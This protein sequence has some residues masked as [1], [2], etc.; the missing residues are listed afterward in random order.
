MEESLL[1]TLG[2]A[3]V[4]G[5]I[6]AAIAKSKGRSFVEWWVFGTLLFII[7]LPAAIFAKGAK[8]QNTISPSTQMLFEGN[9]KRCPNCLTIVDINATKCPKCR[10]QL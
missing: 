6:P 10:K 7:A 8:G 1:V 5:L 4:L 3:I 2:F 9:A